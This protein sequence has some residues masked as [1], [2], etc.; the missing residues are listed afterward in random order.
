M[1]TADSLAALA[2]GCLHAAMY[3]AVTFGTGDNLTPSEYSMVIRCY[4][5]ENITSMGI[6][7]RLWWVFSDTLLSHGGI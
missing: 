4:D 1:L 6:L 2:R 3:I 5:N 7:L